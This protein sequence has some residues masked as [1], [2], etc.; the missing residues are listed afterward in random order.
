M[1]DDS[2]EDLETA[3][4]DGLER[5]DDADAPAGTVPLSALRRARTLAE[6]DRLLNR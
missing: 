4:L 6:V 2:P 1:T 5:A 3:V